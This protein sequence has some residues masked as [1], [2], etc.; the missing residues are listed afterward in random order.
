MKRTMVKPYFRVIGDVHGKI[1]QYLSIAQVASY[2]L[3]VGDMGFDYKELQGLDARHHR[4]LAGN[5]DNYEEDGNGTFSKQT[6]HFLGDA[7]MLTIPHLPKIFFVRGGKSID[8][9]ARFVGVNW[10]AAEELTHLQGLRVL[11]AYSNAKP[12]FVVSHEA[13]TCILGDL[14]KN[15]QHIRPSSTAELLLQMYEIHKPKIWIF[16]HHHI[17]YY[18]Q[19][20]GVK[21]YC[22]PELGYLDF[23]Q[24]EVF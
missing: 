8:Q 4:I 9:S 16:G 14:T 10:W 17:S 12:T 2:S 23:A 18:R 21:F 5:H 1:K 15:K 7:G 24:G 22:V 20:E 3:Q 6:S 13:P 19:L 11:E